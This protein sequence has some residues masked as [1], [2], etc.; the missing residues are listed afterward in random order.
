MP[1]RLISIDTELFLFLNGLHNGFFDFIMYWFSHKYI[2]I[3]LYL[4][5]IYLIIREYKIKGLYLVL[6]AVLIVV[7]TDQL[8]SHLIKVLVKRLRPSHEPS[9]AHIIHLGKEGIG[10]M[11][12][13]VS[14]HAANAFGIVTFLSLTLNKSFKYLKY[15]LILWA[16]LVSYSRIY[17]GVHYPGDI[18]GGIILG[19]IIGF[20]MSRV[21][22]YMGRKWKYFDLN[23][24][25]Y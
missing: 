5:I 9:L 12:G 6:F 7:A 21:Y 1:E 25:K 15:S 22:K 24:K 23:N 10:G 18:I 19:L 14:S 13:F 17:N 8:S 4:F 11:Y 16:V 3:P 2:W 20:I